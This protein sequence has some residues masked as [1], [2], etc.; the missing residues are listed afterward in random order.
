MAVELGIAQAIDVV[1][2]L[3][4]TL[5]LGEKL[6]ALERA[7]FGANALALLVVRNRDP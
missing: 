4:R 1:E 5:I 2:D 7:Q 3:R 6:L